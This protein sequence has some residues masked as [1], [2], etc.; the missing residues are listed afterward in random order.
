[1]LTNETI[2]FGKYKGSTLSRVLRDRSYC[3]W[4]MEQDWFQTNYEYLYNRVNEYDPKIFFLN[5]TVCE[6]E[7]FMN[8]YPYFNLTSPEDLKIELT[9]SDL[10]CY[11]FYVKI[12]EEIKDKIYQRME[13]DEENVYDIKAPTKWLIKF[14]QQYGIQR[15]DL[16]EFLD[17]YEL[18][19]I[20]YIIESVKKEGGIVYKGAQSF[21]IAKERSVKQEKFWEEILK[22]CYGENINCQYK[23][24]KC[25]FDFLNILTNTIFE[26]K[27][28]LK[29]FNEEQH[30][31]YKLALQKYRII[32][33][34][35]EDCLIY[36]ERKKIYTTN[37]EK[38]Q[39]YKDN[40]P[41]L[42]KS[43]YLDKLIIDF[44]IEK[45]NNLFL[46]FG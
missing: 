37:P 34:I 15:T 36:L 41:N 24:E 14:E 39:N 43:S 12:I 11:K 46:L 21:K 33:L 26:C 44:E 17:A 9:T 29:D 38:Y 1:M 2:T 10:E 20:P 16:K 28:S 30:K 35:N 27:L 4:M 19:N 40:I 31:K 25:I 45:I 32:Y 18:P 23:Y 42:K 22:K 13:N 8:C 5:N 3:K 7:D 6:T